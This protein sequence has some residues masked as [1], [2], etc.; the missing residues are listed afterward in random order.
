MVQVKFK[1]VKSD[2]IIPKYA[3]DGD[4]G[5]DLFSCDEVLVKRGAHVLVSTGIAI[6]LP[7]GY[8]AQIRSRSGLA[9]KHGIMVLNS[10]GTIDNSYRGILGIIVK[11]FGYE[12]FYVEKG[13]KIAQM[14]IAQVESAEMIEVQELGDTERADGGFGSSDKKKA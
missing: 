5:L 8:E 2:A 7:K 6:E 14:V 9:L 12:D 4:S 11:N 10:P 13:T 1:K 3:H